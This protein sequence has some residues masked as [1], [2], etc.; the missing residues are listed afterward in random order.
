MDTRPDYRKVFTDSLEGIEELSDL[1]EF[2]TG[3]P[4]PCWGAIYGRFREMKLS[5]DTAKRL[6]ERWISCREC[7]RFLVL[8]LHQRRQ[9]E[10]I[11]R[12]LAE[13]FAHLPDY[14]QAYLVSLPEGRAVLSDSGVTLPPY[15]TEI[16]SDEGRARRERRTVESRIAKL[17]RFE[18]APAEEA[19]EHEPEEMEVQT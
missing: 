11:V 4:L 16:F 1:R 13:H 3:D 12:L 14:V 17:L 8:M 18:W 9:D 2:A 19:M 6:V 7:G 15:F 10:A 5:V